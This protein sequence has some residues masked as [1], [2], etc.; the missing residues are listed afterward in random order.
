MVLT[1]EEKESTNEIYRNLKRGKVYKR[2]KGKNKKSNKSKRK[3]SQEI[4]EDLI[5]MKILQKCKKKYNYG[6]KDI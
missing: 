5:L 2:R 6:Q 4:E 3:F 1:D